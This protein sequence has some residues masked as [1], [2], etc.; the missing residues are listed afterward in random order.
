M[1]TAL[2]QPCNRK[3]ALSAS[4]GSVAQCSA[5]RCLR[6]HANITNPRG[7]LD[8]PSVAW[9]APRPAI[10][11][12]GETR[13]AEQHHRVWRNFRDRWR[14]LRHNEIT[15][16]GA[17]ERRSWVGD[18]SKPVRVHKVV[19]RR[20]DIHRRRK[21]PLGRVPRRSY[22]EVVLCGYHFDAQD[23]L[24]Q[25]GSAK[26]RARPWEQTTLLRGLIVAI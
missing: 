16:R 11:R 8:Q 26:G 18:R 1:V 23:L 5:S 22:G 15:E 3:V 25:I 10:P 2:A 12:I 4:A 21:G 14:G 19:R 24:G 6:N 17:K 7:R 13:E 20:S 9:A